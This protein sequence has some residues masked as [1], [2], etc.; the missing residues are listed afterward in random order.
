M[1]VMME[2]TVFYD[3]KGRACEFIIDAKFSIDNTSYV[4]MHPAEDE[5]SYTYILKVFTDKNGEE[6]LKGIDDEELEEASKVYEELLNEK[7][8]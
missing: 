3:E 7:L 6:A 1:G 8:Q 5:D 4:A 2:K